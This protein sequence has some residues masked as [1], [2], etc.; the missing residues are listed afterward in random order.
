MGLFPSAGG[1]AIGQL[2]IAYTLGAQESCWSAL[3]RAE[4]DLES[5]CCQSRPRSDFPSL[6]PGEQSRSSP[7]VRVTMFLP[8]FQCAATA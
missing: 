3:K 7:L 4:W 8:M 1:Q 2:E 6:G 5:G